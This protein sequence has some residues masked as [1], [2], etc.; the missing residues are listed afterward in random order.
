MSIVNSMTWPRRF[1]RVAHGRV[2]SE[3]GAEWRYLP[4]WWLLWWHRYWQS[5]STGIRPVAYDN[6]YDALDFLENY[7]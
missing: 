1:K 5:S 7:G 4:Q 2:F 6:M 3:H